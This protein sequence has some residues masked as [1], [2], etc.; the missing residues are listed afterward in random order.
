ML[1]L[2]DVAA[3]MFDR[4]GANVAQTDGQRGRRK[5]DEPN[6]YFA[7][8][9]CAMPSRFASML[10]LLILSKLL[11]LFNCRLLYCRR[12]DAGNFRSHIRCTFRQSETEPSLRFP[13]VG[14]AQ[15]A[16]KKMTVFAR[17]CLRLLSVQGWITLYNYSSLL[18]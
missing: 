1:Y 8:P 14:A 6:C 7:C 4:N 5:S 12:S 3:W 11:L 10:H 16:N 17:S 13:W 15:T 18:F 2:I 9:A